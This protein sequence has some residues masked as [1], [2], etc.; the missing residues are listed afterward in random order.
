LNGV[1]L[2]H[3]DEWDRLPPE[4]QRRI[5]AGV[6]RI[7][8]LRERISADAKVRYMPPVTIAVGAWPRDGKIVHGL[9]GAWRDNNAPGGFAIGV[10]LGVGPALCENEDTVRAIL[11]HE[12]AHCF[13]LARVVVDHNDLGTSLDV[14]KGDSMDPERERSLLGQPKE[15]FGDT[16]AELMLWED[17]RMQPS[18]EEVRKLVEEG[19]LF[20][21]ETP[22]VERA[23]FNVP[24]EWKAH[25]RKIRR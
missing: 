14:L 8:L 13:A 2:H 11:V 25:I 18:T 17:E 12:F 6:E 10:I 21:E 1:H 3:D 24:D 9:S 7:R 5:E 16:D 19:H 15:W 4:L 22:I 23:S 20:W